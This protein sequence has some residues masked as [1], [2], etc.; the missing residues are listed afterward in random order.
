MT[1]TV[2]NSAPVTAS[3]ES[4]LLPVAASTPETMPDFRQQLASDRTLL[5]WL[6]TAISLAGLGFV[7]AHFGLFLHHLHG[8]T[9]SQHQSTPRSL[10]ILSTSRVTGVALIGLSAI[11]VLVG[12]TQYQFTARVLAR[13]RELSP[14]PRWPAL[15]AAITCIAAI[16]S[17]AVYL[18]TETSI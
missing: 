7:V 12:I 1:Q 6:R 11:V 9:E 10:G 14:G 3:G 5:A 8:G 17:L 13:H 18:I 2:P 16:L 4:A 15:A